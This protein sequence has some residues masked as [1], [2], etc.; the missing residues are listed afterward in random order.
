MKSDRGDGNSPKG[1]RRA[2]YPEM[3]IFDTSMTENEF[4][5]SGQA[6]SSDLMDI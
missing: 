2:R 4:K 1:Y 6:F 3:N 5:Y